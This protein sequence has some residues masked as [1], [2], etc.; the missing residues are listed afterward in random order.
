MSE[1]RHF[2]FISRFVSWV[3]RQSLTTFILLMEA[4]QLFESSELD[5]AT[6]RPIA[7]E[8]SSKFVRSESFR[9]HLT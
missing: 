6:R 4:E 9:F 7:M 5:L 3:A 1:H 2:Q 8:R